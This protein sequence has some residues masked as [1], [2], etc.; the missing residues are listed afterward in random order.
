MFLV[1]LIFNVI[2]NC[3]IKKYF[4]FI[5]ISIIFF[6]LFLII[7]FSLNPINCNDWSKGLNNTFIDN[8]NNKYGCK[9]KIPKKCP[10]KI[11]KYV[12]DITKIKG[13]NC[14]NRKRNARENILKLSKSP[15]INE[16]TKLIGFPLTNKDPICFLDDKDDIIIQEYTLKNLID[17]DNLEQINN[18][19]FMDNKPEIIVDFSYN[20]F[21]EMII[22]LNY[23]R[24]LSEE[25]KTKEKFSNPYSKN[26]MILYIDSVSRANSIRKL[27][28]TLNFF[29]KFISYKGGSHHH[30]PSETFHSFQ[31]FKYHSFLHHTS[32]NFPRLFYGKPKEAKNIVL[33]TKYLK[34]NGYITSYSSDVCQRDDTRTFHNLTAEESYDHQMLLCDPN[35]PHFNLNIIKCLYGKVHAEF[36]YEYSNQFWHKYK[37]NRK[38]LVIVTND[39][40]EGTLESLKYV[41]NTIF[42]FL[43]NLF[44]E[45]LLKD[46]SIFLLSDHGVGMPSFYYFYNFYQFEEHLPMLYLI[47]NDRKNISYSQQYKNLYDNQQTFITA[48]DIYN[49]IGNLLYGDDYIIVKNK[50]EKQDTPKS[51]EGQSLFYKIEQK[52][53]T[54]LLFNDMANFVCI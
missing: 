27:K 26:I 13:L 45:N 24:T 47:I 7:I 37:N 4:S 9:L 36:L 17:M 15:Y 30:F 31:F 14:S 46:S 25:R 40:H 32:D 48:F 23:N 20:I 51:K 16:S 41:D 39:G 6:F 11:G 18:R 2:L 50:T 10:Y 34:E 28:N 21:G 5:K 8:D 43:N 49:T 33:I 22:N 19:F 53:R 3:I 38:F 29:E 35:K 42:N 12:F 54:P 44:N 52:Y 1:L